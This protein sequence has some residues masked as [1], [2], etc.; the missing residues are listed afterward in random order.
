MNTRFN[1]TN[2]E[3]LIV[4]CQK[5]KSDGSF[6]PGENFSVFDLGGFEGGKLQVSYIGPY[7]MLSPRALCKH[8]ELDKGLDRLADSPEYVYQ[9]SLEEGELLLL[10][11]TEEGETVV[12]PSRTSAIVLGKSSGQKGRELEIDYFGK[13]M[14]VFERDAEKDSRLKHAL[15]QVRRRVEDYFNFKRLRRRAA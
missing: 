9:G 15:K 1:I 12:N 14:P 13:L 5:L 2:R 4:L 6:I 3:G 10:Y 8:P 11:E 7:S